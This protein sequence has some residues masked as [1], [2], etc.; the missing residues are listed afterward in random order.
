[1]KHVVY[2]PVYFQACKDAS[3]IGSSVDTLSI[4][5]VVAPSGA[6]AAS[7]VSRFQVY[8]PQAWLSWCVSTLGMGLLTLVHADSP[9]ALC[10]AMIAI[11]AIG[12]GIMYCK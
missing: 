5:L 6:I 8:R 12:T 2:L 1:M 4:A 9:K 7:F 10:I 3:A 11:Y